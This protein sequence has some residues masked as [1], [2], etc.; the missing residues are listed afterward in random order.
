MCNQATA[1]TD[2]PHTNGANGLSGC[3]SPCTAY[4][5][6]TATAATGAYG[7]AC[8]LATAIID[9]PYATGPTGA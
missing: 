1:T 6:D 7:I 4:Y 5:Q 3:A 9:H 8:N 2:Y